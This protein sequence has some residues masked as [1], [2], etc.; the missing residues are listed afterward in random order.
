MTDGLLPPF[1]QP[2]GPPADDAAVLEAFIRGEQ[3]G[4]SSQFHVEGPTLVASW[5]VAAA[6]RIGART[7]LVRVDLPPNLLP[8]KGTVEQALAAEGMSLLDAETLLA[9]AVAVQVLGLRFSTFD[10]WGADLDEAFAD[11]R[12][13]AQGE[14]YIRES[15]SQAFQYQEPPEGWD[16]P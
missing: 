12:A 11:L 16:P 1:G 3:A 14:G 6:M 9:A 8:V 10:L 4:H 15:R 5:D 2:S 13:A 7:F